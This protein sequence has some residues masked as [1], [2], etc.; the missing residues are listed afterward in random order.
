LAL[1]PVHAK[2]DVVATTPDLAAVAREIGGDLLTITTLAKPVEDPHFVDPKPSFIARLNRADALIT[3][4]AE[5][6]AG[7][8]PPLLDSARNRKLS[9]GTPGLI[10]AATRVNL[11]EVPD[12]LDRSR[13]DVH[14][15][16]NPHFMVDPVNARQVAEEI[17]EAFSRIDQG[18]AQAYR[19]NLDAF[20]RRLERKLSEWEA[21]LKPFV[22]ERLAAYHNTWPYFGQRF[23]LKIDLFLEP[24]PG[25]PPTPAHLASVIAKMR[26]EKVKVIIIEPYQH[27]RTAESVAEATGAKV[28]L[29][30]QQPGAVR[31][32]EGG[33]LELL[34][35]IVGS[36]AKALTTAP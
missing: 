3:G 5:L 34:D 31:G 2:L 1:S 9:A 24:K 22:G 20:S 26:A 16:G 36:V 13:G 18:N 12:V 35:F 23:G 8:L 14:A 15:M 28:L 30:A 32:T 19:A 25:L 11:L 7:W 29:L 6:E 10:L 4:G 21:A 27:R 17:A 33:Y